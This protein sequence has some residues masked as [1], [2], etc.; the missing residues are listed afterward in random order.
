[1]SITQADRNA[2]ADA[3]LLRRMVEDDDAE[4]IARRIRLG[5][6]DH[7]TSLQERAAA[8]QAKDPTNV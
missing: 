6:C 5:W 2:E 8:R 3:Y 1:M 4:D 7:W